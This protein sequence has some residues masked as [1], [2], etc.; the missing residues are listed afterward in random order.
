MP[1]RGHFPP[2]PPRRQNGTAASSPLAGSCSSIAA[3]GILIG[4]ADGTYN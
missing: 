3:S 1:P 4:L 2:P